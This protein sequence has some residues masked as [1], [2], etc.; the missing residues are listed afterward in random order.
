MVDWF[1]EEGGRFAPS[2]MG[3]SV[4]AGLMDQEEMLAVTDL[5]GTT[6]REAMGNIGALGDDPRPEAVAY[7]EIH[8]EQGRILEREQIGLGAVDFSWHTQKLDI[9]VVGEQSHTGATAMA[10]RRDA[11]VA[12]SEVVPVSYTHLT[13]PTNREV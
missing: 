11:L 1:N 7:A 13:L 8:I 10:D 12:A 4:F 5:A 2:I 3:S 9:R 6:V